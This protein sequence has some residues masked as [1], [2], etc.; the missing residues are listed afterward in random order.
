MLTEKLTQSRCFFSST[1]FFLVISA[2]FLLY[3]PEHVRVQSQNSNDR[4]IRIRVN[5][6]EISSLPAD[7]FD[8]DVAQLQFMV[9]VSDGDR[10]RFTLNYYQDAPDAQARAITAGQRFC[11]TD[12]YGPWFAIDQARDQVAV[13]FLAVDNDD[14]S[15]LLSTALDGTS[16]LLADAFMAMIDTSGAISVLSRANLLALALELVLGRAVEAWEIPDTIGQY[17][18][19]LLRQQDWNLGSY[20]AV[21]PDGNL[22]IEYD[23]LLTNEQPQNVLE[24]QASPNISSTVS[25]ATVSVLIC[26]SFED[27]SLLGNVLQELEAPLGVL[28]GAQIAFTQS[29]S[30]PV[31]WIILRNSQQ[32]QSVVTGDVASVWSPDACRPLQRRQSM[33]T[34]SIQTIEAY[35]Y[36]ECWEYDVNARTMRWT[37]HTDGR[38]DVWQ[39]QGNALDRVRAGYTVIFGPMLVPGEI[40]ACRLIINK[41]IR[42][43]A[44]D[45]INVFVPANVEFRVVS[46]GSVG[47]FR[48]CPQNGY[49]YRALNQNHR[50]Q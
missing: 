35:C 20:R 28:A 50:C 2:F 26:L 24:T 25:L 18:T 16:S 5:C 3:V 39:P 38:E 45:G 12:A 48:W 31:G 21:S 10:I 43:N 6:F 1:T 47:G 4:F 27:L 17:Q 15:Q 34:E 7:I 32:V 23:V 14:L 40:F 29:W 13:W 42:K 37:G 8:G 9:F 44:C 11:D 41:T 33:Q 46:D 30:A 49:G 36:G 19:V 22:V